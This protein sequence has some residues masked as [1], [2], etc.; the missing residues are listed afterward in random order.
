MS[1]TI[2]TEALIDAVLERDHPKVL[3]LIDGGVNID[4]QS[5]SHRN[6][7]LIYSALQNCIDSAR[8]LIRAGAKLNL[9]NDSGNTAL[10]I[11]SEYNHK[12]IAQMLINAKA[13]LN[14]RNG[15]G[16]TALIWA[17]MKGHIDIVQMLIKGGVDLEVSNNNGH[18]ALHFA[19]REDKPDMIYALVFAGADPLVVSRQYRAKYKEII[20]TAQQDALAIKQA[21]EQKVLADRQKAYARI[22]LSGYVSRQMQKMT[23]VMKDGQKN[24]PP[25]TSRRRYKKTR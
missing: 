24:P 3:R 20:E 7:A 1:V 19:V 12:D 5:T 18:K 15:K 21:H 9:Q 2:T 14:I 11:A 8:D 17:I 6:T 16:N 23:E 22:D 10:M 13:N 4:R 25:F